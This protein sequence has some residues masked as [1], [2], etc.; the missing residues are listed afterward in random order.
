MAGGKLISTG[1]EFPDATTQTTSGLPLTGGALT[2]AVTTT[3]TFDG[4]DVAADGVTADAALPKAGGT[5]TGNITL[6]TNT[7]DG[8][9]I[10][11]T[12]TSNLGLGTGAVDSITT[13]DYNVGVGDGAL[14][15][16]TT[17]ANNTATGYQALYFN[18]TGSNNTA[19]GFRALDSNTTGSYNTANGYRALRTNT[20]G[21]NNTANG[22]QALYYNTTGVN[23]TAV[24]YQALL[25][26]NTGSSNTALG[27]SALYA[28]TGASNTALGYA[29]G[30]NITT[31]SSNIII[32][33]NID[34]PSATASNQLNIGNWIKGVDGNIGI[35][36]VPGSWSSDYKV[37]QIGDSST[38]GQ[39]SAGSHL[40]QTYNAYLDS[41]SAWKRINASY[42]SMYQQK[43]DG[44]HVW[45]TTGTS[46]A[47]SAITWTTAVNITNSGNFNVLYN[48]VSNGFSVAP[49]ANGIVATFS[50]ST[51]GGYQV[52]TFT[53]GNGSVGGIVTSG[54]STAY[55]TSSD[56]RLKENV[57]PMTGSIDRLKELKPSKF[58]F[59]ADADTTVDGF[60][61][62]EAG[63][64][65]PECATGTKDAMMDEEYEVTPA[66]MD[67]DTVVTEAV[68]GTRSVPDYQGIDQ[69]K[70]VPLLVASLQEAIARI[71]VL[72]NA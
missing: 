4:R 42:G 64:V 5:M 29:A 26:N 22:F 60:L 9:E 24:G 54:T 27:T 32:G 40:N 34:A 39:L 70:L 58:N 52:V 71:E 48:S 12:A 33:Y 16:N 41:S 61:A 31:G 1:V 17:G 66:V 35:G 20:T 68:M 43:S 44:T 45:S 69:S 6:G 51:T 13:G 56:Y 65:V 21:Y 28:T 30:D 62:H 59:I 50:N 37:L 14:T 67:G 36:V 23:N 57:V 38:L 55:N 49:N 46:T 2:G 3:S 10:N 8:L 53:N 11:T 47:D 25:L 7:I 19:N 15:A 72:E 63:E 18:T